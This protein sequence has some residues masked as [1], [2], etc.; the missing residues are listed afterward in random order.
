MRASRPVV[1][2]DYATNGEA[3]VSCGSSKALLGRQLAGVIGV[4]FS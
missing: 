2:L 4:R 1:L 3:A